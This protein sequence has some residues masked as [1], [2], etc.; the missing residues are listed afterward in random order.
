MQQRL[1]GS[2][3]RSG[4]AGSWNLKRFVREQYRLPD[5]EVQQLEAKSH[6]SVEDSSCYILIW[7]SYAESAANIS[8]MEMDIKEWSTSGRRYGRR[9]AGHPESVSPDVWALG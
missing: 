6:T 4:S 9:S 7:G 8:D 3:I 1:I 5:A 2:A